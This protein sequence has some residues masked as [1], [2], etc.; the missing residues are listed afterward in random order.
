M[1]LDPRTE[2]MLAERR[3]KTA[4]GGSPGRRL[5]ASRIAVET[6]VRAHR[7]LALIGA[8]L[9]V[10]AAFAG[11]RYQIVVRPAA[12]R[13]RVALEQQRAAREMAAALDTRQASLDAC[14]ATADSE[15]VARW[16]AACRERRQ[17]HA[18]SLPRDVV[19]QQQ[20]ADT[21]HRTD[22]MRRFSLSSGLP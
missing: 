5:S 13:E 22:C 6:W 9:V 11:G 3:E 7:G 14:L 19:E 4:E 2:K 8:A 15:R 21:D 18:C 16:E 20:R 1:D 12:E 10:V 17:P